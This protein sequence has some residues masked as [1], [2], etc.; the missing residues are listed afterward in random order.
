M[1]FKPRIAPI[2]PPLSIAH[3]VEWRNENQADGVLLTVSSTFDEVVETQMCHA[4][5]HP[6]IVDSRNGLRANSA[7]AHPDGPE[8]HGRLADVAEARE[9]A[10]DLRNQRVGGVS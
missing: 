2:T 9:E 3:R 4:V 1:P 8:A 5:G 10:V 6:L 7:S